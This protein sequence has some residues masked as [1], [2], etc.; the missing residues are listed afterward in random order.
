MLIRAQYPDLFLADM[1]PALDELIHNAYDRFPEQYSRIFRVMSSSRSIEQTS[2]LSGLGLPVE[3]NEGGTMVYDQPVPGFNKTY[4]HLQYGLGFKMT[5]I[6]IDD[7]KFAI[8]DKLASDLGRS[9]KEH[10]ELLCAAVF[11]NGFATNGPDGVPLF[12]ASHPLVKGGGVQS[13][14]PTAAD[15]DASS[16]EL[17]L[18]LF[19]QMKDHSGRKIRLAPQK[20]IVPAELEFAASRLLNSAKDPETANNAI[21]AVK[22]RSGMPSLNEL[23]VW[24]YLTDPDAWFLQSDKEDTQLRFYWRERAGNVHDI[25]FDTRSVKTARWYRCSVGHSSF[26]GVLGNAGAA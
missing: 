4:L 5:R 3:I 7:D 10:I 8:I 21:N 9:S 2:E 11:N 6:M 24:D 23:F 12:S 15:L 25:D 19:R 16:L 26:Y 22:N 17:A 1:L 14:L 20:L 13:N 18:T